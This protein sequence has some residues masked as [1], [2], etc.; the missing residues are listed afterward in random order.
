MTNNFSISNE[1]GVGGYGKVTSKFF[2]VFEVLIVRVALK[3]IFSRFI[4]E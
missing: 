4:E 2:L 1:I 3:A